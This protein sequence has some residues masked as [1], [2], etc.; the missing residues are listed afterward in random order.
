MRIILGMVGV[1][2]DKGVKGS[3]LK[4]GGPKWPHR[5]GLDSL[6]TGKF[7]RG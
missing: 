4:E 1:M 2:G 3:D 6:P 5:T 7:S